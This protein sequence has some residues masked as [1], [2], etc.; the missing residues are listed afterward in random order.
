MRLICSLLLLAAATVNAQDWPVLKHYEGQQ[1]YKIAMPVGGIGTG[2]ISVGGNGQWRDVEIMNKPGVGFFGAVSPKQA[3]CF[4]IFTQ[5]AKGVKRSKALLGPIPPNE[6][7][8]A[9]GSNTP[10]HG[11]PRFK[12]SSFD[13]AYPFAIVNLQDDDMPVSVKLK[14]FNPF[15]PGNADASGIP[16]AVIRYEVKNTTDGELDVAVAGSL[17]N[18]IGMDGYKAEFSLF[19]RSIVPLGTKNNRNTFKSTQKLSG[20]YMTSDSVDKDAS[21]YGTIALTTNNTDKQRQISY[22]T[23]FDTRGWGSNMADMWN[24]FTDD[25]IYQD[26]TFPEKVNDPRA[27]LAV[28]LKLKPHETREVQFLLTWNFPNRKDWEDHVTIGNYYS[29]KY[30]DAWDVAEKV[31][32]Q[33]SSLEK[34][35]L[36]FVNTLINS[37]YPLE[38]KEAALFNASTLRSQ[39]TFRDKQGNYFGWEGVFNNVGSCFG[40]CTHVWNYEFA[41]P[42]LFGALAKNMRNTEYNYALWNSGLMNFRVSL[43]LKKESGMKG[44]AAD[45]Q[46]GS[47]MRVY[48]E[49]QL[50]G[51]DA[52]L[53]A[54]WPGVKKALAFAWIK[55]GWDADKDGVM[56]G[57]QHNTMDI[58]YYGPNPEIEFWYLG[59]LKASAAMAKYLKDTEFEQTCT[60]LYTNGSKWT[61]ANLFNGKFY[62]QKVQPAKSAEDI[63]PGLRQG[64]GGKDIRNPDFQIGEGCLVD[65]LVGQNMAFVCGLGYL[66]DE[67]H[68]RS[69]L[70]SI[71]E[72]N[73]VKTFG[74]RFNNMR[75]YA[76]G[77]EPGLLITAYPDPSKRPAIPLSY[78]D[79][80]WT[81]LEY[82]AATGM[83]YEGMDKEALDIITNVRSRYDGYKRNPFN[84]EE[85]GNH[86]V[87]AMA[88]WSALVAI[89]K[90][91]YSAVDGSFTITSK[92][93]TYFWSNGYAWGDVVV[94]DKGSKPSVIISVH[95]GSLKLNTVALAGGKM[96]KVKAQLDEGTQQ[97]IL[98]N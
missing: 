43:P 73:S 63:A 74:D 64:M 31:T 26:K 34:K 17:D 3:P 5:D 67:A 96:Q 19:N 36:D 54:T 30:T 38:V 83:Y 91:H 24:D 37:S 8:G 7:A 85:C 68:I 9:E 16:V 90:F 40:N 69:A 27:A 66:A 87:R 23:E 77:N 22:R 94:D 60:R 95:H 82:T 75:S 2:N 92:P 33:L 97:R 41:S 81:G 56:E 93:G 48:R 51:D 15:I 80:V 61:D 47:I 55:G 28:K 57:C 50:S 49:W 6:F 14:T 20:I 25:G 76:L 84:E 21:T 78:G 53:K 71:V 72:Y 89:S 44:A 88:S 1:T 35:T 10:S 46:M 86:Y 59:A 13:A 39:T 70:K 98:F 62:I 52:F 45:G 4:L 11:L 29:T 32:P 18:F 12:N 42:F 58:E 79:E 65:Q